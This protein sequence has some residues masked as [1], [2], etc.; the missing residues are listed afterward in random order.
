MGTAAKKQSAYDRGRIQKEKMMKRKGGS[1]KKVCVFALPVLAML[2]AAC[3]GSPNP[4]PESDASAR[5]PPRPGPPPVQAESPE[6]VSPAPE[7]PLWVGNLEAAFPGGA[8][9]AVRGASGNLETVK[10]AALRELSLY[11]QTQVS[12]RTDLSESY[13]EQNGATSQSVQLEQQ[14]L[15]QTE[16]QLFAVRYTDPW[17][18]PSTGLWE[19]VAYIDRNEAWTLFEPRLSS[20]TAPFMAV[21]EAAESDPEPMRRFFRY[22]AAAVHDTAAML[23]YLD[24][25]QILSPVRTAA[26]SPV[27]DAIAA[28][29]QKTDQAR[30]D[31]SVRIECPVDMDGIILAA[32]TRALSGEGFPVTADMSAAGTVCIA[33]VDEGMETREA[34]TFYN[35]A[36]TVSVI[37]I[38]GEALFS[39]T[40]KAPRQSAVNPAIARRR[41]YTALAGEIQNKFHSEFEKQIAHK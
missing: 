30:F 1:Q 29:S 37:G 12:S 16:T 4:A 11:F 14:T 28:L 40:L 24:F 32:L 33:A 38:T 31:A 21:F 20:K 13:R 36:L 8:Y 22:R 17:Q 9:I 5:V 35:P 41:G 25:A 18:S 19:T 7:P 2:C 26:L 23:A 27:R 6:A 10:E 39:L 15:I 34:G 3:A